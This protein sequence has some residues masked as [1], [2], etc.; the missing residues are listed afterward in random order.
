MFRHQRFDP[1]EIALGHKPG[2]D[3]ATGASGLGKALGAPHR[4]KREVDLAVRELGADQ[5]LSK[6]ALGR[7]FLDNDPREGFARQIVS[8][9]PPAEREQR[10]GRWRAARK[11]PFGAGAVAESN[12]SADDVGHGKVRAADFLG[13]CALGERDQA[14]GIELRPA[15]G[16]GLG[17]RVP[18]RD[19]LRD[20]GHRHEPECENGR[21]GTHRQPRSR[22][23]LLCRVTGGASRRRGGMAGG[24]PGPPCGGEGA[25]GTLSCPG[26]DAAVDKV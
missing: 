11:R 1:R 22:A 4:I 14:G 26:R 13:Q 21:P 7:A 2:G 17:Q 18:G 10:L 25:G 23:G 19:V 8:L 5:M 15:G 9:A 20:G 3:E 6:G 12:L 16:F 24:L